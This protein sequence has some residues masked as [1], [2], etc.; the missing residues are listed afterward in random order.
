M[1]NLH[2]GQCTHSILGPNCTSGIEIQ[3]IFRDQRMSFKDFI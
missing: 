1:V 2:D 3:H